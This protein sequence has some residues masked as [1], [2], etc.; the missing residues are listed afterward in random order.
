[1][2]AEI[3]TTP[4]PPADASQVPQEV[5][6]LNVELKYKNTLDVKERN[7][8]Q[9]FR[10]ANL[11]LAGAMIFLSDNV[12]LERPLEKKDIRPRLLGHWVNTYLFIYITCLKFFL[13]ILRELVLPLRLYMRT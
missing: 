9:K 7:A 12:L 11:Y 4:N 8:I 2:P 5:T 3:I 13:K 10:R 1:M 6:N